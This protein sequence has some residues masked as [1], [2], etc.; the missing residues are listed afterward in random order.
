MSTI[1]EQLLDQITDPDRAFDQPAT[2]IEKLQLQAA[3]ELF[4]Q[5]VEQ[6]PLLRRRADDSGITRIRRF[7]DIVP[8]LF[9]H[10]VYKSYPQSLIDNRRWDRLLQWLGALSVDS[11]DNV[12]LSGVNDIDEWVERLHAA[13]HHVLVTSGT[14]GKCS[15]LNQSRTD[16][17][18]KTRHFKYVTGWPYAQP[19]QDRDYFFLGPINGRN[20]AIEA[21]QIGAINWAKPGGV[22]ALSY[23]PLKISEISQAAELRKRMAEGQATP[24]EIVEAQT[25]AARKAEV[26]RVRLEGLAQSIFEHRREPVFVLGLWAQYLMLVEL[27]RAQ[28]IPDGDFHVHSIIKAGGGVKGIA[29]PPDYKDQ[30]ARFVGNVYRPGNY[31]MTEMASMLARCESNRYHATPG[32]IMLVLDDTGE[33]LLGV[34]DARDGRIEGRFGFL[35][36]LFDGRWG[37]VITGDK[38]TIDYSERCPC[39]RFGPT[40]LDTITRFA[41]IGEQDHIGCAGTIDAYVRGVVGVTGDV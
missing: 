35:D 33:K 15:F 34:E 17:E 31:G 38:V 8:L 12:D 23:E 25:L 41:Q 22:H 24:T 39:G 19:N 3:Q 27:A 32:L 26:N 18:R 37:G 6:I 4:E 30:V 21:A 1:R 40:V 36:L 10:T 14:S 11:T 7:D 2:V 9:A 28:G 5:R 29:L 16:F 20:S 13:G